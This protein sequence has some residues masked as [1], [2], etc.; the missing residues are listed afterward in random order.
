[1]RISR[2]SASLARQIQLAREVSEGHCNEMM[3]RQQCNHIGFRYSSNVVYQ[4]YNHNYYCSATKI[5]CQ[6]NSADALEQMCMFFSTQQFVSLVGKICL[7]GL[8]IPIP[9]CPT[10]YVAHFS[11]HYLQHWHSHVNIQYPK[12]YPLGKFSFPAHSPGCGP[13]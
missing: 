9:N 7:Q 12:F 4:N 2:S 11:A 3:I 6:N 10:R 13:R 8:L 1:M 5:Y